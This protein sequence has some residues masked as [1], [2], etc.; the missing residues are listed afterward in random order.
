MY[1]VMIDIETLST[2][3]NAHILTIA[4][5]KFKRDTHKLPKRDDSKLTF[6]RRI[7]HK[8]CED[9]KLHKSKATVEWWQQQS[10]AARKECFD[11]SLERTNLK[12]ALLELTKWFGGNV[13]SVWSHGD[14][15]D[16]VILASAYRACGIE[17]SIPWKFW[18]T[19]DTRTVFDLA[20]LKYRYSGNTHHHALDDCFSQ[21]TH[22][23][24]CLEKL[25]HPEPKIKAVPRGKW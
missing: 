14:D 8:S 11:D 24:K 15:F 1:D 18:E 2:H 19:R 16:L 20:N 3:P 10:A 4:A 7:S 23:W 12:S 6:Y 13:G 17:Q 9:L 25:S 5:V 21:I 22:L